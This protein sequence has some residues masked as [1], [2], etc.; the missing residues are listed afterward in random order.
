MVVPENWWMYYFF[1]FNAY[2]FPGHVLVKEFYVFLSRVTQTCL[3][4][5][6]K[7]GKGWQWA[8]TFGSWMSVVSLNQAILGSSFATCPLSKLHLLT[9]ISLIF[10]AC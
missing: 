1:T 3:E 5:P 7:N 10:V 9:F 6:E 4:N 2:A 8:S